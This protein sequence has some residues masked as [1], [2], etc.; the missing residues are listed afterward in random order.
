MGLG[1]AVTG[2]IRDA[3]TKLGAG[4]PLWFLPDCAGA[5]RLRDDGSWVALVLDTLNETVCGRA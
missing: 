2:S 3:V 5:D 4:I 1:A